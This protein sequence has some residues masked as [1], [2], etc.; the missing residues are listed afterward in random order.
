M[1][2]LNILYMYHDNSKRSATEIGMELPKP[3]LAL[4]RHHPNIGGMIS[5]VVKRFWATKNK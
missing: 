2:F 1:L 4:K 5:N 3:L